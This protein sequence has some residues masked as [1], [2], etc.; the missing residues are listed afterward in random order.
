MQLKPDWQT[1]P[2]DPQCIG[3]VAKPA[4]LYS[5]P[6]AFEPLQSMKPGLQEPN[7]QTFVTHAALAF[8]KLHRFPHPPQFA[9][10]V[11]KPEVAYSQPVEYK[12]SQLLKP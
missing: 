7:T 2:Q 10:S 6:S 1:F 4:A 9:G 8:G 5:Q 11:S 3:S 12:P